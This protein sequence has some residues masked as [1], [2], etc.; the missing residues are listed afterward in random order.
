MELVDYETPNA[1]IRNANAITAAVEAAP[2][3]EMS[4]EF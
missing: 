4:I 2:A 3:E 1:V